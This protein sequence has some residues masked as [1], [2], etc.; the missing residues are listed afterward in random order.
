MPNP[1]RLRNK[2]DISN[3]SKDIEMTSLPLNASNQGAFSLAVP[4]PYMPVVCQ[5][6]HTAM[7]LRELLYLRFFKYLGEPMSEIV[8]RDR[9][10][11][12][13]LI[14]PARPLASIR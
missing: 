8:E 12:L 1:I 10:T 4:W 5:Y 3:I 13:V 11:Y 14:I 7:F 6:P 9:G 2:V